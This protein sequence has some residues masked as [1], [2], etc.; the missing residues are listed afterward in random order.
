MDN[1]MN[2]NYIPNNTNINNIQYPYYGNQ[3]FYNNNNFNGYNNFNNNNLNVNIFNNNNFNNNNYNNNN[4]INNQD[5]LSQEQN[6]NNNNSF[7]LFQQQNNNS[8]NKNRTLLQ[9]NQNQ[10]MNTMYIR[11]NNDNND[12]NIDNNNNNNINQINNIYVNNNIIMSITNKDNYIN[13]NENF[14][15]E[16]TPRGESGEIQNYLIEF[17]KEKVEDDKI[18]QGLKKQQTIVYSRDKTKFS[19]NDFTKAPTTYIY[20]LCENS[21]TMTYITTVIHCLANIPPLAKYFLK[22]KKSFVKNMFKCPFNYYFSR[23]ISNIYSYPEEQDKQF[24]QKFFIDEFRNF[25]VKKNKMFQGNST[26]DAE[27][28]LIFFLQRLHEE[29]NQ[30]KNTKNKDIE[31]NSNFK[32]YYRELLEKNN[33]II[34]D[35]F[36]WI[37]KKKIICTVNHSFIEFQNFF[38]YQLDIKRYIDKS[39]NIIDNTIKISD[40]VKFDLTLAPLYNINCIICKKKIKDDVTNFIS[41]SPNYFIFLTGLRNDNETLQKF[42]SKNMNDSKEKYKFVIDIEINLEDII[43]NKSDDYTPDLSYTIQ[44][45]HKKYQLDALIG[46]NFD[47]Q[48]ANKISYIAYFRSH[49][50]NSWYLYSY[51]EFKKIDETIVQKTFQDSLLPSILIYSHK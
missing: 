13:E 28:F 23:F 42:T 16:T 12:N 8:I 19:Y 26:K 5:Y 9:Y 7:L 22:N 6:Y 35:C 34:F 41:I 21:K 24:Y 4:Y 25:V 1:N 30:F 31:K 36:N 50:D 29:L 10:N 11:N 27:K 49:I 37:Q 45:S 39:K 47:E 20:K 44:N 46:Y 51:A 14:Q 32:E 15:P 43:P 2:N 38:T 48:A 3:T 17:E 40:L 33:S 18:K